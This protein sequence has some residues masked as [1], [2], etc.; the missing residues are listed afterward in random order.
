M[1][2]S[3][4]EHWGGLPCP[5]PGDLLH[6]GIKLLCP[7]SPAL[8]V[9]SLLLSHWRSPEDYGEVK[10]FFFYCEESRT[11]LKI[12]EFHDQIN[13]SPS[14]SKACSSSLVLLKSHCFHIIAH[15]LLSLTF[16]LWLLQLLLSSTNP[17]SAWCYT[18]SFRWLICRNIFL[19][20]G[21]CKFLLSRIQV[22]NS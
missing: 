19:L 11:I 15:P 21:V 13:T 7:A 20:Q 6:P 9:N 3:S 12:S 18:V 5:P 2:F 17:L 4:Q 14:L 10:I 16:H 22:F 1:G 8:Q